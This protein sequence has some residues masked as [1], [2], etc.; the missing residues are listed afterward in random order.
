VR[1]R[2]VILGAGFGGIAVATELRRLLGED[3]EVVLVDRHELFTMGLRKLWAVV[4]IGTFEQGSRSRS[5]LRE[6]GIEFLRRRITGIEPSRRRAHTDQGQLE[7]DYLVVALGAESRPDLVAGMTEHTHNVWDSRG[8]PGLKAALESFHGGHIAVVI[9]GVPYTCPPAP[10]E[11]CMLLDEHLR[12]RGLRGRSKLTVATVQPMLL[13]N[14]GK[15]GSAWLADQLAEREIQFHVKRKVER[16]EAGK[17]V[18]TD[19]EIE[20][21]LLIGVPP[22]RAPA[23][24]KESDLTDAGEWIQVDR[25][26]LE[27]IHDRVFAIG[28]IT[29]IKL[30]NGLPLPKAGVMAELEGLRVAAAIAASVRGQAP[31]PDFDGRGYCFLEMGKQA[32]ALIEGNFFAEPEP[33]IALGEVSAQHAAEKRS[34]ESERLA[35]WFGPE[36]FAQDSPRE[37]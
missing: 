13:P 26:T 37:P 19:G 28:D 7:G 11:C 33:A 29:Q 21:D 36:L 32:A 4:D 14:A 15:A 35:R 5:R 34:F 24:A 23:V 9:A 31:P 8:V 16:F 10:Y 6:H 27:T 22:H 1:A 3:S 2:T 12:E 30:A 25:A 18:F 17:V 20:A